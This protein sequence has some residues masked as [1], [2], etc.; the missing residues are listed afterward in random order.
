[1]VNL[2]ASSGRAFSVFRTILLHLGREGGP[3]SE[4]SPPAYSIGG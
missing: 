4:V 1:M 3:S 2:Y